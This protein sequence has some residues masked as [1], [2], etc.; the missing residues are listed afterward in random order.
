MHGIA[1]NAS[2]AGGQVELDVHNLWGLMEEK[3]N[4][5]ALEDI[6]PQKRPFMISRSTFPSS[7]RWTGHWV[8]LPCREVVFDIFLTCSAFKLG[9]NYSLW[10]YLRYSLAVSSETNWL[11]FS[12]TNRNHGLPIHIIRVF[13]NFS[14]FK[15][16]SLGQTRVVLV[17]YLFF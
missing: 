9:D 8:C 12:F 16:L 13:S 2:H 1:T 10:S 15:F 14:Y 4:H 17:C 7:G 6:I 5:L 3:A 11:I